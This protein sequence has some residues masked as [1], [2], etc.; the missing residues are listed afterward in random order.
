MT[1]D[2]LIYKPGLLKGERILVTG[3]GTGLGRVMGEA[4]LMMGADIHLCG[5]RGAVVEQTAQELM[6]QHGGRATGHACDVRQPEAV[7][8]MIEAIWADGGALTGLVNNAAGNFVSRTEDLSMRAFDAVA[9][10]VMRG[11]FNLTLE[12]GRRWLAEG[13]KASVLSILTTWVWN[14]S[15]F[16]VPSAMA[17]SG[18]HAMTQSLAVEWGNRGIRFNAIAPGLFPTEGMSARLNPQGGEHVRADN[19]MG[20]NGR[21]PELANL[22]VFLMSTQAEYLTG[23][24]IAIDGGQYQATG[25][26]FAGLAS[27]SDQDWANARSAIESRNAADRQ[28]RTA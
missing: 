14:G 1:L 15:A 26:N 25:G 13:R 5:R 16:T 2:D 7:E 18:V 10:I 17:K 8:Q 22:A 11:S 12:C 20:R 6:Q 27:W 19:P 21:M 23:Q 4:F 24:T 28:Q 9:N 3:G